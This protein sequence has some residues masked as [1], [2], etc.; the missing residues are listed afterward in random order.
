MGSAIVIDNIFLLWLA[1]FA[2]VG[3]VIFLVAQH[4]SKT[5][6]GEYAKQKYENFIQSEQLKAEN[7]DVLKITGNTHR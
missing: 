2:V 4:N 6:T 3:T 7:I 5:E 1:F